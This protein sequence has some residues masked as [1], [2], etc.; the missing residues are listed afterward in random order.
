MSVPA[1]VRVPFVDLKAQHRALRGELERSFAEIMESAHFI[2]GPKVERFEEEFADFVGARYAIGMSSGTSALELTLRAIGIGAA[3]DVIVP[4]NSF[5][6]TAEAVSNVGARP[7]FADVDA[8][9]F[10]IDLREGSYVEYPCNH[11]CAPLRLG[12]R[13]ESH[14]KLRGKTQATDRRRRRAG[15]RSVQKWYEGRLFRAPYVFQLLSWEELRRTGGCRCSDHQRSSSGG[16][17]APAS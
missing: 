17:P 8:L 16:D 7:V 11:S 3:D 12:A 10:Q 4:A 15:T 14:R 2:G 9:S 5:F 13:Y 1:P 6:A